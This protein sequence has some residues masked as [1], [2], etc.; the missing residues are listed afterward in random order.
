L[1][2]KLVAYSAHRFNQFGYIN[3]LGFETAVFCSAR[4][5]VR[6]KNLVC[7]VGISGGRG[8]NVLQQQKQS[9]SSSIT[10][11]T[12]TLGASITD[13]ADWSLSARVSISPDLLFQKTSGSAQENLV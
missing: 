3:T 5:H 6:P 8:A 4:I 2:R 9:R 1:R 7:D 10:L 11:P 12:V 13:T